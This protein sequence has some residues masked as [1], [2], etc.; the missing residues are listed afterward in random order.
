MIIGAAPIPFSMKT[1]PR[2]FE[3]SPKGETSSPFSSKEGGHTPN[4]KIVSKMVIVPSPRVPA[5]EWADLRGLHLEE[6]GVL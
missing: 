5:L 6:A 2:L 3:V 4:I 1:T